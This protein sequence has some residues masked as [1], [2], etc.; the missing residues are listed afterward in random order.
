MLVT[1]DTTRAD[2][3]GVYGNDS[4]A[5]PTVDRLAAEGVRFAQARSAVPIT[6]PS[7]ST[8]LT[9]VY[10]VLHGVRDNGLFVLPA[11]QTT[12]AEILGQQ[13]YATAAAIGSFPLTSQFGLDQGF[14]Y[15][16]DEVDVQP[17]EDLLAQRALPKSALFF[18]ERRAGRVNEALLPWLTEHAGEPFFAWAHY[19]DPHQPLEPPAPFDQLYA[20]DLYDGEIAYSDDSLGRLLDHLRGLGVLDRTLVILTAD[21]GEGLNEHRESTH[22]MLLYDS[23]LHVPLILR[24]PDYPYGGRVV[25][26]FVGTVD[27]VPTVLDLLGVSSDLEFQ[28][29]SLEPWF[30]ARS[31]E[32]V[33]PSSPRSLYS[34]TLS[35]RLSHR[36]GELRALID[37]PYKFVHGPRPELFDLE[38]DPRELHNLIDEQA[39]LA[40]ELENRLVRFLRNEAAPDPG[41]ATEADEE[42]LSRLRALGY[43]HSTGPQDVV[44]EERLRSDGLAPQD[45]VVDVTAMSNAKEALHQRRPLS[46]LQF[47][48]PLL[49]ATPDDP[50]YLEMRA[51]AEVQM[52]Q[53]E[54]ASATLDLIR[55]I[56]GE[57]PVTAR[58]LEQMGA[59][60]LYRGDLAQAERWLTQAEELGASANGQHFLAHVYAAQGMMVEQERAL[61]AVLEL[62]P[63][64]V[65]ARLD[66][67]ILRARQGD[68]AEAKRHFDQALEDQPYFPRTH[69]N[70]GTFWIEAGE[71]S[72]AEGRFQRAVELDPNYR[73]ARYALVAL[74]ASTPGR[75]AEAE[76]HRLELQRRHPGSAEATEANALLAGSSS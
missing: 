27:I 38:K 64:F 6:A 67:A 72:A 2:R 8:I 54:A 58:L 33:G 52:E 28:G 47:L 46:A 44:V 40:R 1:F 75:E 31:L 35:P 12:L 68:R 30:S 56:G 32:A 10:P 16:D 22:S 9:G 37:R 39:A 42:T 18:D 4:I 70:L 17:F 60:A 7:H 50:V 11:A 55:Q 25:D 45:R 43:I 13:G 48:E 21:H 74:Y 5:T 61:T 69:Y 59:L 3:L 34:E 36:W 23:T 65:T 24:P 49:A 14:D 71:L 19:F 63:G 66:L 57:G 62:D 51:S 73:Q 76:Y 29:R 26:E 53:L 15:F 20:D 41:A